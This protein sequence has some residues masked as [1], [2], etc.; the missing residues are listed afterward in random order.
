M[1]PYR[2]FA[3]LLLF[4]LLALADGR[5]ATILAIND[6][7]RIGGQE[8][9]IPRLRT[10]RKKLQK[11]AG[12]LLMLHAGDL[13]FP[14][15]LSRRYKGEQ[16][17]DLMN[18]LDGDAKAF[19]SNLFVTFGNHEFDKARLD[20]APMLQQRIDESQF[21]WLGSNIRFGQGGAGR[22][23]IAADN[24]LKFALVQQG[25][26]RIGLFSITTDIK[27]PDYVAGF[28]DPLTVAREYSAELRRRGAEVVVALTH[29]RVARDLEILRVLGDKGPDLIV[30][31]HEHDRQAHR[32]DSHRLVIKADAD[33]RTAAVLRISLSDDGD[34][35][36]EHR[37]ETLGGKIQPAPDLE[38]RVEYWRNRYQR[39]RCDELKLDA[40]CLQHPL[41][42]TQVRLVAE[43]LRIR[44]YETNLGNWVAD[45]ALDAF[46]KQG[47][48][49]AFVNAGSL[50]L[51]RDLPPGTR[52]TRSHLLQLFAY[53]SPLGL[54]R[55]SGSTLKSVIRR[56]VSDWSGNGWWL[57][58]AGFAFRHEPAG[59]QAYDLTLLTPNGPRPVA[60]EEEIL[61]VTNGYLLD[62]AMGQDGYVMLTPD[63]IV[64]QPAAGPDLR[65]LV[66]RALEEAQPEGIAPS[67]EGRICNLREQPEGPCLAVS[68]PVHVLENLE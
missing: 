29:L 38:K 27:H 42:H 5:S 34:I 48:Q 6:V 66:V 57:Q 58:I 39:E 25:G 43:E 68:Q 26:I 36:I 17:I 65:D 51:N 37:F 16:M 56:A 28:D 49:I 11:N 30:G 59:E 4:P 47:A 18:R 46:A 55:L 20:D 15:V 61:A 41:G 12:D 33:A 44:R 7:Y 35:G 31:G 53:P 13:L 64:A 8:G 50:R 40:K 9:G 60:D 67:L 14:S 2:L 63:M 1:T 32:T 19:D 62:P 21:R 23:L 45:Q 52:I 10:L 22:P 24:L 54:V 3:L